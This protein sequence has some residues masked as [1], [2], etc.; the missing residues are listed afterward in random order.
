MQRPIGCCRRNFKPD[1]RF[2]RACHRSPSGSVKLRR[3]ER[4]RRTVSFL[5]RRG[6]IYP[7]TMLRMVPL[8]TADDG[9]EAQPEHPHFTGCFGGG[10]AVS[11]YSAGVSQPVR[12]LSALWNLSIDFAAHSS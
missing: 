10:G 7:S 2:R 11:A 12:S 1:G 6:G 5:S 4:A 9:E 3:K 8:A